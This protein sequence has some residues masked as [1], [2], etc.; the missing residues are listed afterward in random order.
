MLKSLK[1][2]IKADA[3]RRTG[4]GRDMLHWAKMVEETGGDPPEKTAELVLT[5]L[6]PAGDTVNGQFL[7]IKDGIKKPLVSW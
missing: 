6:T 3:S 2:M 4:V 1:A 5:L 7:W